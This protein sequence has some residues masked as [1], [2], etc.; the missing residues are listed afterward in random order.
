MV[1]AAGKRVDKEIVFFFFWLCSKEGF[2]D[3]WKRR[4]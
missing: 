1:G 4:D 2:L 3:S